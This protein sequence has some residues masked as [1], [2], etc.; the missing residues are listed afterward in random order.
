MF[1]KNHFNVARS[2]S[3]AELRKIGRLFTG[4]VV[5]VSGWTDEDKEGGWYKD[6]FPN[7]KSYAVTNYKGEYGWQDRSGEIPLDLTRELPEELQRRFDVVFNHT[8]LEHIFDFRRAFENI[9]DMSSDIVILV[10]PF[11]QV[12][13]YTGDFGDFWRFTPMSI[14]KMFDLSGFGVIHQAENCQSNSAIYLLFVASRTPERWAGKFEC[15]ENSLPTGYAIGARQGLL[16][17]LLRILR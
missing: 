16:S 9:C 12:E 11:S 10:V 8:T 17:R 2:W 3:N 5:N 7:C 4:S 13:H 15:V 14:K 1:T 6:Y